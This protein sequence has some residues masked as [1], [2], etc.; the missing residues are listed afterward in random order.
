MTGI[1]FARSSLAGLL[2]EKRWTVADLVRRI[3]QSGVTLD[4]KT[5]Y[6]LA[7]DEPIRTLNLPVVAAISRALELSDPGELIDWTAGANPPRLKRIDEA[8]QIR[9]DELMDRNT[10]G[11]L[12]AAERLE[13][14]EL[15]QLVEKLSLENA[16]LLAQ[17]TRLKED[18]GASSHQTRV[19]KPPSRRKP[20]VVRYS[21]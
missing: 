18:S 3:H 5:V 7:S 15:G 2:R 8:T 1:S 12:S 19:K 10:E 6:R 16:A 17:R 9:L 21:K 14:E 11:R 4:K 13:F 20:R